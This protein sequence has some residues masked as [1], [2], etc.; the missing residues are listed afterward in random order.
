MRPATPMPRRLLSP[1]GRVEPRSD[2]AQSRPQVVNEPHDTPNRCGVSV[3][4]AAK[5][6]RMAKRQAQGGRPSKGPR[7]TLL[8]RCPPEVANAARAEAERL[9]L[10]YSDLVANVLAERYGLPPIAE[11]KADGQLKLPA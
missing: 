2:G 10:S 11:P 9:D 3:S 6:P 4:V 1:C 7:V 5:M 8:T